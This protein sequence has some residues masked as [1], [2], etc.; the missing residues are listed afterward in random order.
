[1]DFDP[2]HQQHCL[3]LSDGGKRT[4]LHRST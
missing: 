2:F 1:M 3:V 4:P